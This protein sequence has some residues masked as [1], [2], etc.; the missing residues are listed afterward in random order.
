MPKR[1]LRATP[2]FRDQAEERKFW[3]THDTADYID[4]SAA[5]RATFSE[6]RPTTESI[7]LRL[8]VTLLA[9]LKALANERDVPYQSLLKVLLAKQVREEQSAGRYRPRVRRVKSKRS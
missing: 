5:T 7:S 9:D 8:P 2:K 6:L 4:W 1:H 3:A